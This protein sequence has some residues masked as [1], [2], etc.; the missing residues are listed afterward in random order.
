[1][2]AK[3]FAIE[4]GGGPTSDRLLQ[5]GLDLAAGLAAFDHEVEAIDGAS[6]AVLLGQRLGFDC[7]RCVAHS[8]S[9]LVKTRRARVNGATSQ[10]SKTNRLSAG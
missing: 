9:P 6:V 7:G 1:M 10:P 4:L 3:T 8:A 5:E 2:S